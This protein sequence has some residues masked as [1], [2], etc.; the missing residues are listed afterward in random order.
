MSKPLLIIGDGEFADIAFEY[1]TVDSDY[2]VVGFAVEHDYL[3]CDSKHGLPVIALED[4]PDHFPPGEVAA[5]VAVTATKLNRVRARLIALARGAGY[6]LANFISPRAMIWRT[7]ELGDNVFVFEMN[8]VQHGVRIGSGTV[9]WSG[10]HIGH[11]TEIG[12]HCFLSSHIVVSGFCTIGDNS[13]VGVNAAFADKVSVG[14]DCLVGMGAVITK[15]HK[16]AGLILNGNPATP[17]KA[18]S[19][20]YYR[21]TP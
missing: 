4:A 8:V 2:D 6:L 17:A 9:L 1:F 21:I 11:Q 14:A 15:N 10:N 3:S 18:T 16:E 12:A 20:R 13:F 7:A 5:H 19:Y